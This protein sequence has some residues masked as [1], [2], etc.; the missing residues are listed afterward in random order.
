MKLIKIVLVLMLILTS[1]VMVSAQMSG[2][3]NQQNSGATVQMGPVMQTGMLPSAD[4]FV[5]QRLAMRIASSAGGFTPMERA[6]IIAGRINNAFAAGLSWEDMRVSEMP[7]GTWT[8]AIGDRPIA[9]ADSQSARAMGIS[10][11]RLA[12]RW[13]RQTVIAL[14]GEPILVA[15]QID[16]VQVRV[17]GAR[18]ELGALRWSTSP[19]KTVPLF[20]TA[21]NTQL[22]NVMVA[23][24]S[25]NLD[26][27]AAVAVY[28]Y[29]TNDAMVWT[30][31]PVAT[32]GVT[33]QT[34]R[35][36]NVG[37]V[38]IPSGLLPMTGMQT[39]ADITTI[40][41]QPGVP[42]NNRINTAFP[43]QRLRTV[44]ASKIV[45]LYSMES[46]QIIGAAQVV[47]MSQ[48]I[49]QTQ[50]VVISTSGDMMQLSAT[51]AAGPFTAEPE[52][53][54][55]VVV[56]SLITFPASGTTADTLQPEAVQ[57]DQPEMTQPNQPD[58]MQPESST[59]A[60]PGAADDTVE[61]E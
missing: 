24:P 45:P 30:F 32:T 25:A 7:N 28:Q 49:A 41:S 39:G 15:S 13:A 53:L 60:T 54:N 10:T 46:G 2:D 27:V 47:G 21:D 59:P 8:V 12:N 35:I 40:L 17:A 31:V 14:G 44:G 22:G 6:N 52:A 33:N 11:A 43:E 58:T 61:C 16:P 34:R 29:M 38:S 42:W 18:Q 48:A 36:L 5:G 50:S 9:T 56:S 19:T 26:R 4:I 3:I 23:G 1:A 55:N 20:R 37:L 51:S 57:P